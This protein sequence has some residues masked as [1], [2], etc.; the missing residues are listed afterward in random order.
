MA[1][2]GSANQPHDAVRSCEKDQNLVYPPARAARSTIRST[3]EV[4][5]GQYTGYWG[6]KLTLAGLRYHFVLDLVRKSHAAVASDT[7]HAGIID[8]QVGQD[9]SSS[10]SM[11]L[12]TYLSRASPRYLDSTRTRFGL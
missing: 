7:T 12:H 8:E 2:T 1:P 6:E 11:S 9:R 10:I 4:S 3:I 5:S